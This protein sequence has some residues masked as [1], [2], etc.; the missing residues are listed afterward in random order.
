MTTSGPNPWFRAQNRGFGPDVVTFGVDPSKT[1]KN[2]LIWPNPGSGPENLGLG[3]MWSFWVFWE[4]T[5]ENLLP[6]LHAPGRS[7][8]DT[9][10]FWTHD[11]L[12]FQKT[13]SHRALDLASY[14]LILCAVFIGTAD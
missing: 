9:L 12:P 1:T 14:P 8:L 7:P 13:F 11:T 10:T 6:A 2:D 4:G 5:Q 3:Q